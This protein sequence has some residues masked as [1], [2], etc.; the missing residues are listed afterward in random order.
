[1]AYAYPFELQQQAALLHY[2]SVAGAT[3]AVADAIRSAYRAAMDGDDNL[4]AFHA[5]VDPYLA[6][7][8]DYTW[9]SDAI[10]SHQGNMFYDLVTY[11]LDASVSADAARAAARYVHYLHGVNPLGLV[12]L[13]NMG[14]YGAERSASE[15]Y[16]T[17]F[18]DGSERWD[19]VGVSTYGPAP[20]FLT[21]GPSPSYDKDGCCP[22]GCGSPENNAIC[23][24]EPVS[25]PKDQPAQKSYKD[26]NTSWPLNS[27]AVTENSNGYQAS[28]IRLLSKLVR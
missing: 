9:G 15:F 23:D 26:F 1:M 16:H 28:Y 12:Y 2:T 18:H 27:W 10:K 19:R 14:A 22:D 8:K 3:A 24:A 11:E 6:Y 25:P 17:W 13:S 4:A 5:G 7:L 21:G 20:G